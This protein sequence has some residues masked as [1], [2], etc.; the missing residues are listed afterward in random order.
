LTKNVAI[1][2][3]KAA[4]YLLALVMKPASDRD[5]PSPSTNADKNAAPRFT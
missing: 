2:P 4:P 1:N 3:P 5:T